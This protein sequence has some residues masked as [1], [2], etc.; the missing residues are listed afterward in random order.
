MQ[1]K[2]ILTK[3]SFRDLICI[4]K[5]FT[6]VFG[7]SFIVTT[8]FIIAAGTN[9]DFSPQEIL[10]KRG[11]GIS[12]TFLFYFCFLMRGNNMSMLIH[13]LDQKAKHLHD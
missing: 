11:R 13:W 2:P 8:D 12:T 7:M 4:Q 5:C 1:P 3:H 10:G 9:A 6:H